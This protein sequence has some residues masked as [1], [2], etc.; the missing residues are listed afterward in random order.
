MGGVQANFLERRQVM[1]TRINIAY[2][3]QPRA[4]QKPTPFAVPQAKQDG[5]IDR[6][7]LDVDVPGGVASHEAIDGAMEQKSDLVQNADTWFVDDKFGNDATGEAERAD[8]PFKTIEEVLAQVLEASPDTVNFDNWSYFN[9]TSSSGLYNGVCCV[10]TGWGNIGT[11][12]RTDG[13]VPN[14]FTKSCLSTSGGGSNAGAVGG[15]VYFTTAGN[16]V[17]INGVT[18]PKNSGFSMDILTGQ[19]DA[20]DW[21]DFLYTN[22]PAGMPAPLDRADVSFLNRFHMFPNGNILFRTQS[23][24]TCMWK[25]DGTFVVFPVPYGWVGG[26][27][28]EGSR[29]MASI[30]QTAIVTKANQIFTQDGKGFPISG[31]SSASKISE[32]DDYYL[33]G[34]ES[35]TGAKLIPKSVVAALPVGWTSAEPAGTIGFTVANSNYHNSYAYKGVFYI[36]SNPLYKITPQ[37]SSA[38]L[39]ESTGFATGGNH[40]MVLVNGALAYAN[41]TVY[42]ID[43]LG[44]VDVG[45]QRAVID[46]G[47]H[48]QGWVP[49]AP[50]ASGGSVIKR[51]P[52]RVTIRG[53]GRANT[54]VDLSA[55]VDGVV[56]NGSDSWALSYVQQEKNPSNTTT[57]RDAHADSLVLEAGLVENC[58]VEVFSIFDDGGS[59]VTLRNCVIDVFFPDTS[60]GWALVIKSTINKLADANGNI[61]FRGCDILS[62]IGTPGNTG[63]TFAGC[64]LPVG[65]QAANPGATFQDCKEIY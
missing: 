64:N 55:F 62:F 13:G 59:F 12:I 1:G 17:V 5:K 54:V 15:K 46:L 25:T 42:N 26:G 32:T 35:G 48:Q 21:M 60:G 44:G 8:K 6:G 11:G 16:A 34:S 30:Y 36:G 27:G 45:T 24:Q 52:E 39:V 41:M 14:Q 22:P 49:T 33:I 53:R 57:I 51:W 37:G 31:V 47:V 7:W 2:Y 38:P 10:A 19:V 58:L 4:T 40:A 3:G 20:T 65:F 9:Q 18:I 29:D 23:N 56:V 50:T 43:W 63:A 61:T 28:A